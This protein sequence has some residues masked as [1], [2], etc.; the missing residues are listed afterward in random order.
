MPPFL[1]DPED[2]HAKLFAESISSFP[3]HFE[4]ARRKDCFRFQL[5][6]FFAELCFLNVKMAENHVT[7]GLGR[8][9]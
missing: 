1:I 4:E 3:Y 2:S 7:K 8:V 9:H 5:S 6:I